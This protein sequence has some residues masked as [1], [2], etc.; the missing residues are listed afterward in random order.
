MQ[1]VV[2]KS[3]AWSVWRTPPQNEVYNYIDQIYIADPS[4][5]C[6]PLAWLTIPGHTRYACCLVG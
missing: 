6:M 3:H 5:A 2:F 1:G 4:Q